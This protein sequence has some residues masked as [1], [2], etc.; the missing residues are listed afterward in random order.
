M[1]IEV[2]QMLIKSNVL[3][4]DVVEEKDSGPCKDL[5]AMKEDILSECRQLFIKLLSENPER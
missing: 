3:Q 4:K 2:K 1:T 5:E